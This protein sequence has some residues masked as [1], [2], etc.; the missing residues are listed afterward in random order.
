MKFNYKQSIYS[1]F[2][3]LFTFLIISIVIGIVVYLFTDAEAK[4]IIDLYNKFENGY[5]KSLIYS[6][7]VFLCAWSIWNISVSVLILLIFLI[8]S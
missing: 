4:T 3:F 2:K 6:L 1:K 7:I 8:C 5:I